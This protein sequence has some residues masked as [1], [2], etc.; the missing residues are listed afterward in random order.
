M[1]YCCRFWLTENTR[2]PP[3]I[4]KS[5]APFRHTPSPP[6]VGEYASAHTLSSTGAFLRQD[7]ASNRMLLRTCWQW[8]WTANQGPHTAPHPWWRTCSECT[9]GLFDEWIM[10]MMVHVLTLLKSPSPHIPLALTQRV[11][12]QLVR[13]LCSAHG[14]G[15]ILLVGKDQQYSITQLILCKELCT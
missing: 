14:V 8:C 4:C 11:Q 9:W 13:N 12:A 6:C 15:Q 7:G 1:L 3:E 2:K 10:M 5:N